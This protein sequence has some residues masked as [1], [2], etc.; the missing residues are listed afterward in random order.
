VAASEGRP[1]TTVALAL[2]AAPAIA[3]AWSPTARA[4]ITLARFFGAPPFKHGRAREA[5]L[6][7]RVDI[8]HHHRQFV[9]EFYDVFHTV[10]AIV[11]QLRDVY[12]AVDARQDFDERAKVGDAR[13]F[14]RVDLADL[15]VFGHA[16]NHRHGLCGAFT[17][18]RRDKHRAIVLDVHFDV[19]LLGDAAYHLAARPDD[20]ANLLRID[21]DDRHARRELA[22]LITRT[23]NDRE[24]LL[25]N[26][27]AAFT[28]LLKRLAHDLRL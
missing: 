11:G 10:D 12:H 5:N 23:G 20:L 18:G 13:H 14:T 25:H 16:A 7:G 26:E 22:H 8:D 15:G 2:A 21:L 1:R 28:R 24:H 19:E 3:S 6:S 9:A 27:H 4:A 17:A